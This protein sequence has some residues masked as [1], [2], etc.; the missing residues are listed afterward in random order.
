M[1]DDTILKDIQRILHSTVVG[2]GITLEREYDS[3]IRYEDYGKRIAYDIRTMLFYEELESK[4][5]QEHACISYPDGTWNYFVHD[6][7]P[8]WYKRIFPVKYITQIIPEIKASFRV[9]YPDY[10]S[11]APWGKPYV[12]FHEHSIGRKKYKNEI[13]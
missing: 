2:C 9:M 13:D 11:L 5:L 7:M 6:H 8:N 12:V 10:K 1:S 4:V 3:D